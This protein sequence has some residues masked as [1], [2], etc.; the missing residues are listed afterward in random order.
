MAYQGQA[1]PST[2]QQIHRAK[3]SDGKSVELQITGSKSIESGKFYLLDNFLG[4]AVQSVNLGAGEKANVIL[5]IEPAEYETDQINTAELFPLGTELFWD[6]T[7]NYFTS[8]VEEN[9]RVGRVTSGKDAN[10]AIW[11]ILG[12]L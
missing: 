2:V 8:T 7:N 6:K 3:V 12:A 4:A 5:T 1:T 10:N 9:I 11:F